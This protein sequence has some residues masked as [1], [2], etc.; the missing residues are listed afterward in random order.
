MADLKIYMISAG[1][2]KGGETCRGYGFPACGRL[3]YYSAKVW[4]AGHISLAIG[5]SYLV[6]YG[7]ENC[8]VKQHPVGKPHP[9]SYWV[10]LFAPVFSF[11][12]EE[13]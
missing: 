3:C 7:C 5:Q 4:N 9:T 12:N 10:G 8:G 13:M 2:G 6:A 1:H 11:W